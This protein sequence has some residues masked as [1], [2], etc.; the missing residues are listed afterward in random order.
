MRDSNI[1]YDSGTFGTLKDAY[2]A[3]FQIHP[4]TWATTRIG[5][6][7]LKL[8]KRI[9]FPKLSRAAALYSPSVLTPVSS[10]HKYPVQSDWSAHTSLCK[11][12]SPCLQSALSCSSF[13]STMNMGIHFANM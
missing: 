1:Y 4:F 9:S 10:S 2:Y 6:H 7:V 3:H 8:R 11:H 13:T 5:L 12:H